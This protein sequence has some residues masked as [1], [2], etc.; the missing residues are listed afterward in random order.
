MLFYYVFMYEG[1]V[2]VVG[3]NLVGHGA[4]CLLSLYGIVS[5]LD[6]RR[7]LAKKGVYMHCPCI[8]LS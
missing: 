4:M 2:S 6:S 7:N 3:Y 5:N 1:H 8:A